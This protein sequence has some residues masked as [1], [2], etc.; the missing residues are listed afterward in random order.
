MNSVKFQT[1]LLAGLASVSSGLLSCQKDDTG[2]QQFQV[3]G[4]TQV[5]NGS[6]GNV[7]KSVQTGLAAYYPFNGNANDESGNGNNGTILGASL[8][9]DRQGKSNR[10]LLFNGVDNWVTIPN[11]SS[12]NPANLS[13]CAWVNIDPSNTN[14]NNPIVLKIASNGQPIGLSYGFAYSEFHTVGMLYSTG[15]CSTISGLP[16]SGASNKTINN[17]W[18][19]LTITLT[20]SGLL[21]MYVNGTLISTFQGSAPYIPCSGSDTHIRL[22]KTYD[23]NPPVWFKGKM[24]EIRIYNRILSPTEVSYLATH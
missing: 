21:S 14:Q 10:A 1:V 7:S 24:D 2:H 17:S 13:I 22:G 12:L 20:N 11:S 6:N 9:T 18:N 3:Q 5:A 16:F 4:L 23:A 19:H 15:A 8:T